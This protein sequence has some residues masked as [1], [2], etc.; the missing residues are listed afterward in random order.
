MKIYTRTGDKGQT[1][2]LG[3]AR[4]SKSNIRI[5]AYGTVDELNAYIGL[6]RD[7]EAVKKWTAELLKIQEMLFAIGAVLA[8]EPGK[9][10]KF[11]PELKMEDISY[12]ENLIDK[13]EEGLPKMKNFILP[14]GHVAVSHCHVAR[15]I[16]RR[17]ERATIALAET[18][19][20]Q[21][22]IIVYLNRLSDC[23]FVLSR[24]ISFD[25]GIEEIP[26]KPRE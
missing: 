11:V 15:C 6:L 14:G 7:Q 8:T 5:E 9:T 20:V 25:L 16:C 13:M 4:V 26:W 19:P 18:S 17:A 2:L 23:L 12:L 22:T 21:E 1:S 3:G 10:F 24:R